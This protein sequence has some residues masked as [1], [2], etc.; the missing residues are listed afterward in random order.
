MR[1][2]FRK[3]QRPL[4]PVCLPPSTSPRLRDVIRGVCP[5]R[6]LG[7]FF[8]STNK[9]TGPP[10]KGPHILEVADG[11]GKPMST[12]IIRQMTMISHN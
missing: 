12:D 9:T 4:A 8:E 5:E 3:L 2:F 10:T 6:E 11:G 7:P 1:W